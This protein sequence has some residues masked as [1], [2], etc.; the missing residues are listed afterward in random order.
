MSDLVVLGV[1]HS[2]QLIEVV[3]VV[4]NLI[5]RHLLLI[6]PHLKYVVICSVNWVL[7]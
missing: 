6:R 3:L 7:L 4:C 5:P 2:K 1:N